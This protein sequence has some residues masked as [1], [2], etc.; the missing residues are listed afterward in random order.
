ME[1]SFNSLGGLLLLQLKEDAVPKGARLG[2]LIHEILIDQARSGPDLV[3]VVSAGQCWTYADLERESTRWAR[4]LRACSVVPGARIGVALPRTCRLLAALLGIWRA[5]CAYVPLDLAYPDDWLSNVVADAGVALVIADAPHPAWRDLPT[6]ASP[7]GGNTPDEPLPTVQASDLAYLIFTS[8]TSGRPKGVRITH[9]NVANLAAWARRE[10]DRDELSA[11]LAATSVC[12]D[13]SVFELFVPLTVG[14]TAVLVEG[15]LAIADEGAPLPPTLVNTV[16][17]I[18]TELLRL[19]AL[20]R[21]TR[22]VNLAGETLGADLLERIWAC[23]QVRH[24]RNL[25]GPSETTTYSTC[26]R[27]APGDP[28]PGIGLPIDN[29]R[30]QVLDSAG[31]PVAPGEVGE[32]VIGGAGV[33]DGYWRRPELTGERFR[34]DPFGG[35]WPLLYRTGDLGSWRADGTLDCHGRIDDQVKIRGIRVEIAE[36][37]AR[38]RTLPGVADAAV[39]AHAAGE[40]DRRL[41]AFILPERQDRPCDLDA[42]RRQLEAELPGPMVPTIWRLV[43]RLP[44]LANG[45]LDRGRLVQSLVTDTVAAPEPAA[46]ASLTEVVAAEMARVLGIATIGAD[47]S[48]L[49]KGGDSLHAARLAFRL[50]QCL[51]LP[52]SAAA[53]LAAPTPAG[54]AARLATLSPAIVE[55]P[56][57]A[58]PLVLAPAQRQLWLF[59]R[60]YPAAAAHHVGFML[61]WR[62]PC[63]ADVVR[64]HCVALARAHPPLRTQ[65]IGADSTWIAGAADA[66]LPVRMIDG[67]GLGAARIERLAQREMERPFDLAREPPWRALI[68]P[69]SGAP[70]VVVLVFHQIV[71]DD[72]SV[73]TILGEFGR[74]RAGAEAVDEAELHYRRVLARLGSDATNGSAEDA[75]FWTELFSR[76]LADPFYAAAGGASPGA[77]VRRQ[78]D[79]ATVARVEAW[80]QSRGTTPYRAMLATFAM[81][82]GRW[83]GKTDLLIGS[84]FSRRPADPELARALG[85]FAQAL[86]LRLAV[87]RAEE[88]ATVLARVHA[89]VCAVEARRDCP[90]G[91]VRRALERAHPALAGAPLPVM[92]GF[93]P[94]VEARIRSDAAAPFIASEMFAP[95]LEGDLHIQVRWGSEGAEFVLDSALGGSPLDPARLADL[96]E[97][98]LAD[99]E[100]QGPTPPI[101]VDSVFAAFEEIAR[102][103][104]RAVALR[105]AGRTESYGALHARALA[106]AARLEGIDPGR[107]CGLLFADQPHAIAAALACLRQ[108]LAFVPLNPGWSGARLRRLGGQLDLQTVLHAGADDP[109]LR[110]GWASRLIDIAKTPPLAAESPPAVID[111]T[112]LGYVLLTSGSTGQPKGVAQSQANL[113]HHVRTYAASVAM[114]PG[115]RV[116]LLTTIQFDAGLMDIFGALLSGAS[117]HVWPLA[118]NGL[119]GLAAWIREEGITILHATPSVFRGLVE[120]C[121]DL[122]GAV[123]AVRA[124]VLGGEAAGRRDLDHFRRA[125]AQG[126]VLVNGFGP[127]ESTTAMQARFDHRSEIPGAMLPIG[128]PVGGT[129]VALVDA[130]GNPAAGVGEIQLSGEH[131]FLGYVQQ[132][133]DYA[134]LGR[135]PSGGRRYRTGDLARRLPDGTLVHL[136]RR[137]RQT[138]ING[139]RTEPAEIE[140]AILDHCPEVGAVAVISGGSGATTQ[141][142]A[143]VSGRHGRA[144]DPPSLADRLRGALPPHFVPNRVVPLG[145]FPHLDNGKI[146]RRALSRLAARGAGAA[147][148]RTAGPPLLE[149]ERILGA[150]WKDVLGLSD[151]PG[152][153]DSFLALGGR[154]LEALVVIERL[155]Q[156]GL[157]IAPRA[158]LGGLALGEAA[159]GIGEAECGAE[160]RLEDGSERRLLP[161]QR[162]FWLAEQLVPGAPS[163]QVFLALRFDE[164]LGAARVAAALAALVARHALLRSRLVE[165]RGDLRLVTDPAGT[166]ELHRIACARAP[167]QVRPEDLGRDLVRPFDLAAEWPVRAAMFDPSG[168]AQVVALVFHH[169][170][171]DAWSVNVIARDL[172]AA[173]LQMGEAPA[174][175]GV[176]PRRRGAGDSALATRARAFWQDRLAGVPDQLALP[177]D[178][179]R[180]SSPSHASHRAVRRLPGEVL[181][182]LDAMCGEHRL[183]RSAALLAAWAIVLCAQTGQDA[184]L[185]GIPVSMRALPDEADVVAPLI[186]V[187]VLP[188]AMDPSHGF[189]VH[190]AGIARLIEE[191]LEPMPPPLDAPADGAGESTALAPR[192]QASYSY[193]RASPDLPMGARILPACA[194]GISGDIALTAEEDATGLHLA[195]DMARDLFA[196]QRAGRVLDQLVHV[197]AALTADPGAPLKQVDLLPPAQRAF[198]LTDLA[199]GRTMAIEGPGIVERI[200][201]QA[202]R[203]P[204]ATAFAGNWGT[205]RYGALIARSN[206]LA[207][208]LG[209]LGVGRGW[210]VPVEITPGRPDFA[211]AVLAL[212]KRGAACLPVDPCWPAPLRARAL[213]EA[214][215]DV[216]IRANGACDRLDRPP[217][218]AAITARADAGLLYAMYTSGS[219]GAPKAASACVRGIRNRF[220]WMSDFIQA[221][222]RAPTTIQTTSSLYDSA[223]WQ[224]FWP[225]T[226]G[227]CCVIADIETVI[228]ADALTRLI[229]DH[230]VDVL[231]M[232]PSVA[233]ALLPGM[234][235]A[236][237]IARRLRMLRW[238][239]LG[240]ETL[241][242]GVAMRLRR[243]MPDARITNLYG[244]TEA[245]IGCIYYEIGDRAGDR[246]PIGRPIPNCSA[247]VLDSCGRPAPKGAPG[248]LWLAGDCVGAGYLRPGG[249]IGFEPCPVPEYRDQPAY[250]TGDIVRWTEGDQLEYRGRSDGQVKIRGFRIEL[251]GLE[252]VAAALSGVAR[253]AAVATPPAG[254]QPATLAL[255]VQP[256]PGASIRPGTVR[257]LL[258]ER[259][260][261]SH[262][263]DQVRLADRI[264]LMASGKTDRRALAALVPLAPLPA[265]EARAP[266]S[267]AGNA[268]RLVT[269]AWRESLGGAEEIGPMVNFFDAGG[270]SF[271]LLRLRDALARGGARVTILQL[272]RNPTIRAQAA[273]I[274]AASPSPPVPPLTPVE[275]IECR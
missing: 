223:I 165:E 231:D 257:A 219:T 221:P 53:A 273:L 151:L 112:S 267:I 184:A 131:L 190:A 119:A 207:E 229:A 59:N 187:L 23:P 139:I 70:P 89:L 181:A 247:L 212:W 270:H 61:E 142:T 264:P 137:D 67:D 40:N 154:S 54:L 64:G 29:T 95:S 191:A 230:G 255:F 9:G 94:S 274:D 251:D 152:R 83:S 199:P 125:F 130:L 20:P 51:T 47:E 203:A 8:G 141:L 81:A 254:D 44:H 129:G 56:P 272:F 186:H 118:G 84:A 10:F 11:V 19:G 171:V 110:V 78:L 150:A 170:C 106:I 245:S 90:P 124:V 16:P 271:L 268:E 153:E 246:P 156:A 144:I 38:L 162:S 50:R 172:A 197:V 146:D 28:H 87:D 166:P 180:P 5:G 261:A 226:M 43:D 148:T 215:S 63:A 1:F 145:R 209:V 98:I 169:V 157:R 233:T 15:P 256:E 189:G 33:A 13:L 97:E 260:P 244:P 213:D 225:L 241:P 86:P 22:S 159:A 140:Q 60:L 4:A 253:A 71:I 37:E 109:G 52:V 17:S 194:G 26:A 163:N 239:I 105:C 174:P 73:A 116:A 185:I 164:P 107:P 75:A 62:S 57:A 92:F 243:L 158:L 46:A 269:Q 262:L 217:D 236:G 111:R 69:R 143:F 42:L 161:L 138:K 238:V 220:S 31:H 104:P 102:A 204:D 39:A 175:G 179:A 91:A 35:P 228:D 18:M 12:F 103:A 77:R 201:D 222:L 14:G 21:S 133:G 76:P 127:T 149:R 6:M 240:G 237:D 173:C 66:D 211:V 234:E 235:A 25:Y 214:G 198:L 49:A 120:T 205:L 224:L 88:A 266:K 123:G 96:W 248:A 41:A 227:G 114:G 183:T 48:F 259:L 93:L 7:A 100:R 252:E 167:E 232:V 108:G 193:H 178:R 200:D 79:A 136:G 132:P 128:R 30:I 160:D 74:E 202:A 36:V 55:P 192:S 45:K 275:E 99:P 216:A 249:M 115:D 147:R 134:A 82:L 68:V 135:A 196:R 208:A 168:G 72:R 117:L 265:A 85:F 32:I 218:R 101:A 3:A 121:P 80:A 122:P 177:A 176:L 188:V 206:R 58:G 182:R 27:L 2:S 195:V 155:R 250:R 34:P 242:S 258:R 24:V 126:T 65:G 113:V 210:V 263:P